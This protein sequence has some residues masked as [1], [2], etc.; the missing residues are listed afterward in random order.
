[1]LIQLGFPSTSTRLVMNCV[2]TR[3]Y[4]L[5]INGNMDGYFKAVR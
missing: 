4:S 3:M 5:M 1:M 2:T